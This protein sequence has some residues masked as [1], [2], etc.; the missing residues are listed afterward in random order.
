MK[1]LLFNSLTIDII[2][3]LSKFKA[4]ADNKV[5]VTVKLKFVLE[6]LENISGKGDMLVI[7][8]FSFSLQLNLFLKG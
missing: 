7:G 5:N 3:D 8:I 1:S 4:Q 2:L 6:R